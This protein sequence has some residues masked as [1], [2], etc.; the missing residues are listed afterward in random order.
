MSTLV[1]CCVPRF[2]TYDAEFNYH[3][4][5]FT[6]DLIS[7][8]ELRKPWLILAVSLVMGEAVSWALCDPL[9]LLL[10]HED[11]TALA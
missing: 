1:F 4:T 9:S 6:R 5:H 11:S 8:S 3:N 10:H 2:L 7:I